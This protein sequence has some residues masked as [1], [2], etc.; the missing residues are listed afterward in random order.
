MARPMDQRQAARNNW[1]RNHQSF[2]ST[3]AIKQSSAVTSATCKKYVAMARSPIQRKGKGKCKADQAIDGTPRTRRAGRGTAVVLE[4]SQA[5]SLGAGHSSDGSK[6]S[7]A[8][9]QSYRSG[10]VACG[11]LVGIGTADA[12]PPRSIRHL[13]RFILIAL[14]TGTRHDR[15]SA[16]PMGT[17]HGGRLDRPDVGRY[18]S[19][20][21]WRCRD[22]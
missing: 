15:H 14:Y 6:P 18:V 2:W 22:E 16:A 9:S 20:G 17:E 10:R 5:G 8:A 21:I 4:G 12:I 11:R 3:S 1:R 13:A 7:P 19:T